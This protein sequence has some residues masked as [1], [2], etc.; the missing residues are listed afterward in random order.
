MASGVDGIIP[1]SNLDVYGFIPH[2]HAQTV[3]F[4]VTVV[5]WIVVF[6][7]TPAIVSLVSPSQSE[8]LDINT[9]EIRGD[10]AATS[11]VDGSGGTGA[12]GDPQIFSDP[13]QRRRPH[14]K[15]LIAAILFLPK[16]IGLLG[17]FVIIPICVVFFVTGMIPAQAV[18][19]GV[20]QGSVWVGA[21]TAVLSYYTISHLKDPGGTT[22]KGG[23]DAGKTTGATTGGTDN[24]V[25]G[26]NRR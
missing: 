7:L 12:Q 16:R 5:F 11:D 8:Q 9:N 21:V 25:M 19:G 14:I 15:G 2:G 3:A 17:I 22:G 24:D 20:M 6:F 10:G 18:V 26:G 1:G 13:G 23:T 4:W